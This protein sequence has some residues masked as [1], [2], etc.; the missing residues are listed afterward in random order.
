[1]WRVLNSVLNSSSFPVS[2]LQVKPN[3]WPCARCSGSLA[4]WCVTNLTM[5][6]LCDP[7]SL[8]YQRVK[9]KNNQNLRSALAN[10]QSAAFFSCGAPVIASCQLE[11]CHSLMSGNPC[12]MFLVVQETD[13][14]KCQFPCLQMS[15]LENRTTL[16]LGSTSSVLI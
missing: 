10:L 7:R 13:C 3:G 4:H 1:M 9:P 15:E 2:P 16:W 5:V 11:F 8:N 12:S 14:L 6:I